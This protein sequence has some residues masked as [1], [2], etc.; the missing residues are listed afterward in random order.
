[1]HSELI[2]IGLAIIAIV[3]L[4]KNHK[5]IEPTEQPKTNITLMPDIM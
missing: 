5:T 1:M 3:T 2:L 4:A